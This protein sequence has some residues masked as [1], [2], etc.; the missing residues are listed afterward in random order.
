[1]EENPQ[2]KEAIMV[3]V[4]EQMSSPE[5]AYVKAAFKRLKDE[6]HAKDEVMKMLGAV[7]TFEI[8]E[9]SV[10]ERSFD[11]PAYIERLKGLPNMSWIDEE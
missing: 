4:R 6:G 10:K 5:S 9:M 7:L 3:A 8:W 1:M 2:A 11:E